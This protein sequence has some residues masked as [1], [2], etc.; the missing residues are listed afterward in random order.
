MLI[1][2]LVLINPSVLITQ[3][4]LINKLVLTNQLVL[5]DSICVN[6]SIDRLN[7]PRSS[8]QN[9]AST[10]LCIERSFVVKSIEFSVS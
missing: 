1:I 7:R 5:I 9:G 4:E 3:L 2:Q 10:S 8:V 6:P